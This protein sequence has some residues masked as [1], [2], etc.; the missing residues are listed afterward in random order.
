LLGDASD[1]DALFPAGY[2]DAWEEVLD[3]NDESY[4]PAVY[5]LDSSSLEFSVFDAFI[6]PDGS[7]DA[8]LWAHYGD[9]DDAFADI[10]DNVETYQ[11][12]FM[13]DLAATLG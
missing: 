1:T 13:E 2:Y 11:A 4:D 6:F 3:E 8:I 7:S 10:E 5:A 9:D 12:D